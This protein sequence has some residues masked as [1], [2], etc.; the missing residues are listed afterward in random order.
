MCTHEPPYPSVVPSVGECWRRCRL[1]VVPGRALTEP[2]PDGGDVT[3][4]DAAF[5]RS[6]PDDG[7]AAI[8]AHERAHALMGLDVA[9]ES[10]ADKV[11]GYLMHCWGW[12]APSARESMQ[13]V[14]GEFRADAGACAFE[15]ARKAARHVAAHPHGSRGL[16]GIV[17]ARSVVRRSPRKLT[18]KPSKGPGKKRVVSSLTNPLGLAS[19]TP[20]PTRNVP[21]P[22]FGTATPVPT[23]TTVTTANGT[24]ATIAPAIPGLAAPSNTAPSVRTPTAT[25]ALASFFDADFLKLVVSGVLVVG[26]AAIVFQRRGGAS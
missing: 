1:G 21:S 11:G 9:C 26:L 8:I 22:A 4:I 5:F 19:S 17:D 3:R 18:T 25:D 23:P 7:K 20:N 6:L 24:K 15:G 13:R 2:T 12:S 14:A 16:G 10:C